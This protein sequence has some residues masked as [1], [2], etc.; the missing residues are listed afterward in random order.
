MRKYSAIFALILTLWGVFS[1]LGISIVTT[2]VNRANTEQKSVAVKIETQKA[3]AQQTTTAGT[4]T[5][6]DLDSAVT[7]AQ[8]LNDIN[9]SKGGITGQDALECGILDVFCGIFR[10]I[11]NF[12]IFIP[13]LITAISGM[14]MDLALSIAINP[15][16]YGINSNA[17][18]TGLRAAWGIIRDFA[19]IGFIFALFVI[20]FSLILNKDLMNFEPKK[21]IVK[22][23]MMALLI[24]FSFLM[25]RLIIQTADIF[26]H[27]LFSKITVQD[28]NSDNLSFGNITATSLASVAGLKSPSLSIVSK[29]N[30]QKLF[31]DSGIVQKDNSFSGYGA[32]TGAA[33]GLLYSSGYDYLSVAKVAAGGAI[34]GFLFGTFKGPAFYV[35]YGAMAIVSFF[36]YLILIFVFISSAFLFLGRIFGLWV[37][38]ILSPIAFVSYTIPALEKKEGIGFESWLSNFVG[39]AFATPIFM[40]FLYL[41]TVVLDIGSII[42]DDIKN[43]SGLVVGILTSLLPVFGAAF[44]LLKGKKIATDMSGEIGKFVG[45]YA[46]MVGSLALGAATGGT[47]MLGRQTFGRAGAGVANK[48][49]GDNS[50]VGRGMRT[51]GGKLGAATF[52]VRNNETMMK[53]FGKFTGAAGEPVDL[54][55][56]GMRE[57]GFLAEGTLPEQYRKA[58][59]EAAKKAEE[60]AI[61][62]AE[63]AKLNAQ[64]PA[65]Q[66]LRENES[67]LELEKKAMEAE[68]ANIAME[69][70]NVPPNMTKKKEEL[71]T[72]LGTDAS[73]QPI[74]IQVAQANIEAEKATI[75]TELETLT[76]TKTQTESEIS[77][78]KTRLAAETDPAAKAALETQID[79]KEKILKET[80]TKIVSNKK[81]I[82]KLDEKSEKIKKVDVAANLTVANARDARQQRQSLEAKSEYSAEKAEMDKDK[83]DMEEKDTKRKEA[84]KEVDALNKK[85]ENAKKSGDKNKV[86]E[87]EDELREVIKDRDKKDTDH[88]K[89]KAAHA[90]SKAVYDKEYGHKIK[91]LEDLEK[92]TIKEYKNDQQQVTRMNNVRKR[93]GAAVVKV[94]ESKIKLDNVNYD[95]QKKYAADLQK[96]NPKGGVRGLVG[97]ATGGALFGGSV[98]DAAAKAA[99]TVRTNITGK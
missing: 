78:L 31:I 22:V 62:A 30:P 65:A 26:S 32:A 57:G 91:A 70:E 73:G 67:E 18:E 96:N 33:V 13:N 51:M 77:T 17:V 89:A 56:R 58:Q 39:L 28:T 75:E 86:L 42:P 7:N 85:L 98:R 48:F 55:K 43:G 24:N 9:K 79:D 82:E 87:I 71:A 16:V 12:T 4:A 35:A 68:E 52:D 45:K 14:L 23:I 92:D 47:A 29:V 80:D 38:I 88:K 19:N 49:A 20:A 59:E 64:A 93:V 37:G 3:F 69:A 54:G 61:A 41:T 40:F 94:N 10:L 2:N 44:M 74:T 90:K 60:E 83:K 6:V 95:L 84:Q 5:A 1:P 15:L 53:G 36:I 72:L 63:A 21:A 8:S 99:T 50:F 11:V 81:Q 66:E 25:C 46:G 27:L 34:G 97:T 76:T